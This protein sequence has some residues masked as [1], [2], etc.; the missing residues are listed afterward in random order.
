[1]QLV[2]AI[3]CWN[4]VW[5]TLTRFTLCI[6]FCLHWRNS[7]L[8]WKIF[9]SLVSI[10]GMSGSRVTSIFCYRL[11]YAWQRSRTLRSHSHIISM[12]N[13]QC[14][15]LLCWAY[16]TQFG[17]IKCFNESKKQKNQLFV[18]PST[19]EV[20][21]PSQWMKLLSSIN[22]LWVIIF[23]AEFLVLAKMYTGHKFSEFY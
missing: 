2:Y 6:R 10:I 5:L 19:S 16:A 13:G 9:A 1:M 22:I 4:H 21:I 20:E 14:W 8:R 3:C 18:T 11:S 15:A 7:L 23:V 17:I 12:I